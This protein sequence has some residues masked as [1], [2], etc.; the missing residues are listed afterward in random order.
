MVEPWL[1]VHVRVNVFSY[2]EWKNLKLRSLAEFS[3]GEEQS[4]SLAVAVEWSPPGL[5]KHD[6][7]ALA[8]LTTNLLLSIWI[9]GPD[10]L[11]VASWKRVTIINNVLEKY[12]RAQVGQESSTKASNSSWISRKRIRAAAWAPHLHSPSTAERSNTAI[13]ILAVLV[14]SAEVVFIAIR[15]PHKGTRM[16]FRPEPLGFHTIDDWEVLEL[17]GTLE[18]LSWEPWS[19]GSQGPTSVLTCTRRG[20]QHVFLVQAQNIGEENPT[21]EVLDIHKEPALPSITHWTCL[22]PQVLPRIR[23]ALESG[24]KRHKQRFSAEHKLW[25]RVT[26][27][28][29]G[30]A[31]YQSFRALCITLHPIEFIEYYSQ[32]MMQSHVL[33]ADENTS[34]L[35]QTS[36][37]VWPWQIIPDS[38]TA[39][40]AHAITRQFFREYLPSFLAQTSQPVDDQAMELCEANGLLP[41]KQGSTRRTM[42]SQTNATGQDV[43]SRRSLYSYICGCILSLQIPLSTDKELVSLAQRALDEDI[44]EEITA[45]LSL[46]IESSPDIVLPRINELIELR[47][48]A[49][50]DSILEQCQICDETMFWKGS[51]VARCGTG[52]VF[53]K[54]A[55]SPIIGHI[56]DY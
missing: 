6:R 39:V 19:L 34:D 29:W 33:F 4:D 41:E 18:K 37:A 45:I 22:P 50:G 15:Q 31:G 5:A 23:K 16:E 3:I 2:S 1:H 43:Q 38:K 14:D 25:G 40:E 27:K 49:A 53:G 8:V 26:T 17:D 32:G 36:Q 46:E 7:C 35:S 44:T 52:H 51:D 30:M 47:R 12:F 28:I 24:I 56:T 10:P 20:V 42:D 54:D 13:G 21:V 48:Q 11:D 55:E 9:P